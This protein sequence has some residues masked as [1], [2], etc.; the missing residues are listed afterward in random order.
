MKCAACSIGHHAHCGMQTWCDCQN[1]ED[2]SAMPE[3]AEA[4]RPCEDAQEVR[5]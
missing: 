3:E 1:L 5:D 2:G 4:C